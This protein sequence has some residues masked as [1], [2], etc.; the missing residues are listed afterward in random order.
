MYQS[1]PVFARLLLAWAVT[2]LAAAVALPRIPAPYGHFVRP[3]W[4]PKLPPRLAW[5]LM[6]SP[7]LWVFMA[8]FLASLPCPPVPALFA[9]LWMGHY[10]YR[11][12]IYPALIRSTRAVPVVVILMAIGFHLA[13]AGLQTWEL[14]RIKP[15]RPVSW[16]WDPRFLV[17]VA[18]FACGFILAVRADSTLRAL[19]PTRGQQ[20]QVPRGGMFER[21]SCPHYLGE[22][23]EWTGWA[24]L[25]WTWA[26]LVFALWTAANL[27]PRAQA[28]HRSNRD[29]FP[30]YPADRKALIPYVW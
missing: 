16:L 18:M 5:F 15:D 26:G 25:T 30:D 6:E 12:F 13:T 29:Q 4:G 2:A 28:L 10:L 20:Y 21:V 23:V 1:H 14:Y 9:V 8:M 22:L 27:V 11:G 17:G 19:R 7:G 3:G 24:I